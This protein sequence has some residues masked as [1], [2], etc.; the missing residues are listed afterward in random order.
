MVNVVYSAVRKWVLPR[1]KA[2]AAK[3][4]SVVW[5]RCLWYFS[6]IFL[7]G[8]IGFCLILPVMKS[9][10]VTKPEH[11]SDAIFVTIM[12]FA[13]GGIFGYMAGKVAVAEMK[14]IE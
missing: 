4:G 8:I 3:D 2:Y 12:L 13:S 14:D 5:V 11:W 6:I 7:P 1:Y 9:I 10:D